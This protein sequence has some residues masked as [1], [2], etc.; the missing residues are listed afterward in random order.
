L[1]AL[2]RLDARRLAN[3]GANDP[4]KLSIDVRIGT[5]LVALHRYAEAEPLLLATVAALENARGVKVY[6]TRGG[7]EALRDL[8]AQ[9][10]RTADAQRWQTKLQSANR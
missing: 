7:Y 10:G 9:R 5:C 4:R 3:S 2:R 8:Y 1:T 6:S